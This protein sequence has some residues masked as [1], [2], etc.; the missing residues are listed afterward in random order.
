M[1]FNHR[2][3]TTAHCTFDLYNAAAVESHTVKASL[4]HG[5]WWHTDT[6]HYSIFSF[7]TPH[8]PSAD[9]NQSHCCWCASLPICILF[10]LFQEKKQRFSLLLHFYNFMW[11]SFAP[12]APE[13]KKN[14]KKTHKLRLRIYFVLFWRVNFPKEDR[15]KIKVVKDSVCIL[16][17]PHLPL[18][19]SLV[20]FVR[21]TCKDKEEKCDDM[22][23]E[24]CCVKKRAIMP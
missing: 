24:R 20:N 2:N 15:K 4:S 18:A 22:K 17:F 9:Q 12:S 6:F 19:S 8:L 13:T 21:R 10:L 1:E 23:G 16:P 14:N 5:P 3:L 11:L 7:S